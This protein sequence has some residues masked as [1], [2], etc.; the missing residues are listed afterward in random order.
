MRA[1]ITTISPRLLAAFQNA[2]YGYDLAIFPSLAIPEYQ[3]YSGYKFQGGIG[4]NLARSFQFQ[5]R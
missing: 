1:S 5:T 2:Q 3:I 4:D